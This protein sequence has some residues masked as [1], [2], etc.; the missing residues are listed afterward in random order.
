MIKQYPLSLKRAFPLK[1]TGHKRYDYFR[2]KFKRRG[3][4]VTSKVEDVIEQWSLAVLPEK[5]LYADVSVKELGLP[6]N[7]QYGQIL[8]AGV[9][10]SVVWEGQDYLLATL[11]PVDVLELRASY[12]DQPKNEW[13]RA[14]MDGLFHPMGNKV[15]LRLVHGRDGCLYLDTD[16]NGDSDDPFDD[17]VRFVW[18]LIPTT[19]HVQS[20]RLIK[21]LPVFKHNH[22]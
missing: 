16:D 20:W 4:R 17:H 6:D 1:V 12:L 3:I 13:L 21:K 8:Y 19:P 18:R 10:A 5:T 14:A 11:R 22:D 9:G 15:I 2:R 7:S